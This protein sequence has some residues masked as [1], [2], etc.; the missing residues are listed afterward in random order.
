M[1]RTI[2]KASSSNARHRRHR[3]IAV[4]GS[5]LGLTLALC[6]SVAPAQD[7]PAEAADAKLEPDFTP[8]FNGKDLTGWEANLE[9]SKEGIRFKMEDVCSV[10]DGVLTGTCKTTSWLYTKR[11]DYTNFVLKLEWRWLKQKSKGRGPD[12]GLLFRL[13]LGGMTCYAMD[14]GLGDT[15]PLWPLGRK[16]KTDP[17]RTNKWRCMPTENAEKPVEQWNQCVIT[18]DGGDLTLEVNGKVINT[19]TDAEVV[20]GHIGL[21]LEAGTIQLR[22]IRIKGLKK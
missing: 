8:L 3:G 6:G 22:N 19:A 21:L 7:A 20:A 9:P 16:C 2:I 10:S 14:L 13:A 5:L 1:R 4:A 11:S 15:G 12:A 18:A 17:K